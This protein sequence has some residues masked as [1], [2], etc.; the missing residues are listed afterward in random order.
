MGK[1]MMESNGDEGQGD[2]A[3]KGRLGQ[4]GRGL[5]NRA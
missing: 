2:D 1:V 5:A 4:S 3:E